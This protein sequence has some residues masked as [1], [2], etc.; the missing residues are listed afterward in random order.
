M[1]KNILSILLALVM[2]MQLSTMIPVF[3]TEE[4]STD[5]KEEVHEDSVEAVTEESEEAKAPVENIVIPETADDFLSFVGYQV[6]ETE[7]NGL[8]SK[9]TVTFANMPT[10]E[11]DNYEVVEYGTVIASSDKLKNHGEDLIVTKGEDGVYTTV[12]YGK[13]FTIYSNDTYVG[14][15][16][17]INENELEYACTVTDFKM[18]NYKKNVSIRGY[19]V[20]K[21]A[22]GSEYVVYSDY[23]IES[24]RSINL[25]KLCQEMKSDGTITASNISYQDVEKFKQEEGWSP[26]W[27]P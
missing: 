1:K 10:M 21:D 16:V 6:R 8:R 23:P 18:K 11:D 5:V 27:R 17:S 20:L 15:L 9:F 3:A 7:Y 26:T 2:M 12:S 13:I 22:N 4:I 24:Y 19:A 25:S 14:K